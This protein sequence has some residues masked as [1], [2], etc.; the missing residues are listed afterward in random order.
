MNLV[1]EKKRS[2]HACLLVALLAVAGI[3]YSVT[4]ATAAPVPW[5]GIGHNDLGLGTLTFSVNN[6]RAKLTSLQ[7]IMACTDT[8][9]GA[10]SERAFYVANGPTDTLNRNRFRFNFNRSAGG[11][12]GHVRLSGRLRSN[13]GGSARLELNAIARDSSSGAVIERCQASLN[14]RMTRGRIS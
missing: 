4:P 6:G 8:T 5:G 12:L 7:A 3:A 11:R 14:Y 13:G 10:E 2:V 9:D 1:W